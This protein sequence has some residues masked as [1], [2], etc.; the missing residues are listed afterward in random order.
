MM[1]MAVQREISCL[2]TTCQYHEGWRGCGVT[3]VQVGATGQCLSFAEND[4][5]ET[6]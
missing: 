2:N 4:S 1:I 3:S 6:E 5:K